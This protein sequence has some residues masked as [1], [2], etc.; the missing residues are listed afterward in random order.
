MESRVCEHC[1]QD[2]IKETFWDGAAF[3]FAILLFGGFAYE[4]IAAGGWGWAGGIFCILMVFGS[5]GVKVEEMQK[6][7]GRIIS[8]NRKCPSCGERSV[9]PNSPLGRQVLRKWAEEERKAVESA[10]I[11]LSGT[12][13]SG[14]GDFSNDATR[15]LDS[16]STKEVALAAAN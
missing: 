1:G 15:A 8:P 9:D 2:F 11:R 4:G 14:G 6:K 16:E 12:D 5:I 3:L 7:R 13:P 10:V